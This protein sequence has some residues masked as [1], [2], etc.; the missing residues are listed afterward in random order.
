[1]VWLSQMIH[2]HGLAPYTSIK[3]NGSSYRRENITL[4]NKE[5]VLMLFA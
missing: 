4:L 1:M 2:E 3:S 5:I